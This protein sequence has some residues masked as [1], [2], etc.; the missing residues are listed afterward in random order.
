AK[1]DQTVIE[2]LRDDGDPPVLVDADPERA[3][4][5]VR[6]NNPRDIGFRPPD[7]P[8]Q[9][10][11]CIE[12]KDPPVAGIGDIEGFVFGDV[13]PARPVEAVSAAGVFKLTDDADQTPLRVEDDDPVVSGISDV[14]MAACADVE[15]VG[16]SEIA[17]AQIASPDDG[18]GQVRLGRRR[19][20]PP[21]VIRVAL[22]RDDESR[23]GDTDGGGGRDRRSQDRH[24]G[25]PNRQN[26]LPHGSRTPSGERGPQRPAS[27]LAGVYR[28][29]KG[30]LRRHHCLRYS[31]IIDWARGVTSPTTEAGEP[32][33]MTPLTMAPKG[34]SP[35]HQAPRK[36]W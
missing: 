27:L 34:V 31:S 18:D 24:D 23:S 20:L 13:K 6:R 5:E 35:C 28:S 4:I 21:V 7:D 19:R 33:P 30:T 26:Q 3:V 15:I 29:L 12:V 9:A 1:R 36:S 16:I 8:D 10:P 22:M 17:D 14:N 32:P 2:I 11:L 25:K